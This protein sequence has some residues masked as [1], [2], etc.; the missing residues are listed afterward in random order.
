MSEIDIT[1]K[2]TRDKFEASL[3][4]Y[5]NF[6]SYL[7]SYEEAFNA[8]IN[9]VNESGHHVDYLAYPILF[10]ARHALELG[11]K[12]NIRYFARYSEKTDHV[13]SGSHALAGLFDAFKLH[14]RETIK[15]LKDKHEI[16]VEEGDI[17]EYENYCKTLDGLVDRFETLD[18][19]SFS[20]RYPVDKKNNKVFEAGDKVNI[21][22]VKELFDSAMVLLYHTSDVFSKY[23]DYADYIE[24][25]YDEE[26]RSEYDY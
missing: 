6:G 23:T 8:L 24:Q 9:T 22:D 18:R 11:F 12:A 14:V 16:V 3:G 2:R 7:N 13:N 20:F 15:N 21:L 25:M 5:M 4:N 17:K 1:D 19:G 26:M 10:T